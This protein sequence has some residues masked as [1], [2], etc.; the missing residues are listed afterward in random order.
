MRILWTF[1][2]G[3]QSCE[4]GCRGERTYGAFAEVFLGLVVGH[5]CGFWEGQ[6]EL[7]GEARNVVFFYRCEVRTPIKT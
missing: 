2:E 3:G 6:M 1:C 5:L 7:C 4:D